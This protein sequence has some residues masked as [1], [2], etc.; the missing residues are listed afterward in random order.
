M[1][2]VRDTPRTATGPE[3]LGLEFL[4]ALVSSIAD[5]ILVLDSDCRIVYANP[6][7]CDW[8]G[9][10]LDRLLGQDRLALMPEYERPNYRAFLLKAFSGS[11]ELSPII[12]R[13]PDGSELEIGEGHGARPPRQALLL[14]CGPR[15]N[16]AAQTRPASGRAGLGG[17]RPRGEWLD[18]GRPYG[19]LRMRARRNTSARSMGDARR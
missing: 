2:D 1:S 8:L 14:A 19:H 9:Y 7:G 4:A 11:S 10:P 5:G 13:R 18:R 12:V 3:D 16:G 17:C 15:R 6:V